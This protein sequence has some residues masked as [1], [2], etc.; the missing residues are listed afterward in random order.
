VFGIN[1]DIYVCGGCNVNA[2]C[3]TNLGGSYANDTGLDGK[4]VFTGEYQFTV[5][6][7]EVFAVNS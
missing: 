5:K 7:I 2:S 6:E 4:Q 3:Y 1:A